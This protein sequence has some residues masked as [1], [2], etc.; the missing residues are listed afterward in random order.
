MESSVQPG[1]GILL[2]QVLDP[3]RSSP[4]PPACSKMARD[5]RK[6]DGRLGASP[7]RVALP[8]VGPAIGTSAA[9]R[10][11]QGSLVSHPS[12]ATN[13]ERVGTRLVGPS[14]PARSKAVEVVAVRRDL[15]GR[16]HARCTGGPAHLGR[17]KRFRAAGNGGPLVHGTAVHP[18]LRPDSCPQSAGEHQLCPP[19]E[20]WVDGCFMQRC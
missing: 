19:G 15:Y 18:T 7:P 6:A 2:R 5:S 12:I 13:L 14:L 1:E 11:D 4:R 17:P 9:M 16:T 3:H 20:G 8:G 10:V